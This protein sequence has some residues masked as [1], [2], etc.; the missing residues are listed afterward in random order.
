MPAQT[1]VPKIK[2][3]RKSY[4]IRPFNKMNRREARFLREVSERASNE[5]LEALWDMLG[6]VAPTAP[7]DEID[8]LTAEQVE[9]KLRDAKIITGRLAD[10]VTLGESAA[11]TDS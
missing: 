7:Q 9:E 10:G 5:D 2:I 6:A 4:P 3:G 11:S 8:E 1:E